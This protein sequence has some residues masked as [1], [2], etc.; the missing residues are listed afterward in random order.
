MNKFGI[1]KPSNPKRCR[2]FKKFLKAKG[3][4]VVEFKGDGIDIEASCGQLRR[5]YY[6]CK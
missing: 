5:H 1:Y 2:E 4:D 3:L 6:E